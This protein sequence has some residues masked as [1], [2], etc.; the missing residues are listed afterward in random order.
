MVESCATMFWSRNNGQISSGADCGGVEIEFSQCCH[1]NEVF[2]ICIW[3]MKKCWAVS[4]LG[5]DTPLPG[6]ETVAYF[7]TLHTSLAYTI[8]TNIHTPPAPRAHITLVT[9]LTLGL[10]TDNCS[11]CTG[12]PGIDHRGIIKTLSRIVNMQMATD[13]HRSVSKYTHNTDDRACVCTN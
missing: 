6:W 3:P 12:G 1:F 4:K 7:T 11:Q 2:N 5:E 9:G 8:L 10:T 13:N